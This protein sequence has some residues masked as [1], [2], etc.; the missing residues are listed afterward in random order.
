MVE[1][2]LAK[3]WPDDMMMGNPVLL[4]NLTAVTTRSMLEPLRF[5]LPSTS[6]VSNVAPPPSTIRTSPFKAVGGLNRLS[7]L[8]IK[9]EL[10]ISVEQA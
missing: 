4:Y 2:V 3:T 7:K 10:T 5:P 9:S 1:Q 6:G 8:R